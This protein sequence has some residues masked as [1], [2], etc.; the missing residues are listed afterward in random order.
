MYAQISAGKSKV[1]TI[2]FTCTFKSDS[3]KYEVDKPTGSLTYKIEKGH[4]S[5]IDNKHTA[6]PEEL[7]T[8][9]DAIFISDN[10]IGPAPK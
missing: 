6:K 10:D 2:E 9:I 8:I 4:L 3:Y 7:H 1:L 5:L